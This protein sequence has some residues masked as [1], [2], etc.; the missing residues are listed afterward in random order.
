MADKIIWQMYSL[1]DR[2]DVKAARLFLDV[3][4]RT[5]KNENRKPH[6][7]NNQNNYIQINGMVFNEQMIN[8]LSPDQLSSIEGI[9]KTV[10]VKD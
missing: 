10:T 3:A 7:I 5:G 8:K 1:A 2:G 4:G 6:Q 9:L